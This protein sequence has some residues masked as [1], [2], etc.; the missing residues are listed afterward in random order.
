MM[1]RI[2]AVMP[3]AKLA[4]NN[5]PSFNWTLN[6]RQQVYDA[7]QKAGRDVS[8]YEREKLMSVDYDATELAAEADEKIRTFQ[9][10]AA[11][12][13]GSSTT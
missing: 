1:D 6:F 9:R 12:R 10:D 2:R 3:N 5:S 7:W 4:Y 8:A 13:A 11:K